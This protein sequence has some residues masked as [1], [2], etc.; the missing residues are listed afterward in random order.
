MKKDIQSMV[1]EGAALAWESYKLD[2]FVQK[3]S[4]ATFQFQEKVDDLLVVVEQIDLEVRALDTCHY[5]HQTFQDVLAK[6][7][8]H[9]DDL[10]LNQY[11]NLLQWVS[12]LD[13]EV[14]SRH[15]I[16]WRI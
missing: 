10:S 1:L 3:M 6:I 11:S 15:L 5:V 13:Q 14:R 8:K 9:V 2:P 12:K 16:V 7:Q 4:E